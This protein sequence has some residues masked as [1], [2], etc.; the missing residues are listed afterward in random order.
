MASF[1]PPLPNQLA[2]V[3][4]Q[5][6]LQICCLEPPGL[7]APKVYWKHPTGHIISDSGLVRVQDNTLIIG[8]A[9]LNEDAG[10]YTCV[11]ENLAGE[12]EM[13][14]QIIV[15]SKYEIEI[16]ISVYRK[17]SRKYSCSRV[18]VTTIEIMSLA[19]ELLQF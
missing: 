12:T 19:P 13:M 11:A 4:E 9:R 16:A 5:Q 6:E 7:P 1:E 17:I 10:N 18:R 3:A 8:Q 2:I 14:V 15:S